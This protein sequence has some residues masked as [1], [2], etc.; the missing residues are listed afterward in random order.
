MIKRAR[1]TPTKS[2][3]SY[4]IGLWPLDGKGPRFLRG[5]TAGVNAVAFSDDGRALY[6]ASG[7]GTIR[8]WDVASGGE[9]RVLVHRGFGVN[10]I[11]LGKP[12]AEGTAEWLAYGTVNGATRILDIATGAILHDLSVERGPVLAL[13]LSPNG[14]QLARGDGKGYI[15]IFD[16]RS[17]QVVQEF[18][19]AP[20]GPIWALAFSG[21]N[22]SILAG[23]IEDIVYAWPFDSVAMHAPMRDSNPQF[24]RDPATMSN[25]ERQFARKCSICHALTTEGQRRAGPSLHGVFGRRAGSLSDYQYSNVLAGSNIVWNDETIDQLFDLGPDYFIP[26]SKMPMQRIR[27]SSDRK[28][29]VNFLKRM[30]Q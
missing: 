26:G 19:A 20:R 18:R 12:N 3:D 21:D 16:T 4:R 17:W 8:I 7:D 29:L 6:S 15:T 11:V 22:E 30:T 28:D 1:P 9:S 24:L 25:G 10:K 5:H 23:G 14:R 13:T 27:R 2:G